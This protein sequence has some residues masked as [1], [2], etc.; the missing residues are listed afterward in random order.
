M[1]G[2]ITA[3]VAAGALLAACIV[4][5]ASY[6]DGNGG[7]ST[8]SIFNGGY[9]GA[10]WQIPEPLFVVLAALAAA[11]VVMVVSSRTVR[12]VGAGAL[13]AMGLQT[14]TMWIS[15]TGTAIAGGRIGPGSVIGLT[16]SVVLLVGGALALAGLFMVPA[17]MAGGEPPTAT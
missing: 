17:A 3:I 16:G 4:P 15:Y 12:A 14:L 10:G 5:Y 8:S 2:G 13:V 11:I 9:Q 1:A 6:P 7:T